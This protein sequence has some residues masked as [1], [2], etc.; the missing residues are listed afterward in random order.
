[1]CNTFLDAIYIRLRGSADKGKPE[2]RLPLCILG[3]FLLPLAITAY[4]WIA[5]LRLPVWMLLTSVAV[6][7]FTL[8]FVIIPISAYI[9][10]ACGMFSA[11]AM[12][13]IIVTRCLLSTFLPLGGTPLC[14]RIGYGWGMTVFGALSLAL[15]IFPILLLR[16]GEKWRQFSEYTQ[17]A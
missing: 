6:S 9:V 3:A 13:G 4:G 14:E 10:D 15:A 11:S 1:M 2:Y 12:T 8:L 16:H 7:G 5:E 17:D